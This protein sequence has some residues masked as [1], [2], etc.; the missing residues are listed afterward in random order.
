MT[1]NLPDTPVVARTYCPGCEPGADPIA[2]ILDLRW[3][4]QHAPDREG[5]CDLVVSTNAYL[6]GSADAGGD[7]NR[8]WCE[9]LHR[10]KETQ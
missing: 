8:L 7:E 9:W 10:R 3:C 1:D 6:S 4:N 2:E 5:A